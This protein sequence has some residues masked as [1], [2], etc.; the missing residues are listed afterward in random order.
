[1]D[2]NV[3]ESH[4]GKNSPLIVRLCAFYLRM[5]VRTL[6]YLMAA[7]LLLVGSMLTAVSSTEV[8]ASIRE[9][10]RPGEAVNFLVVGLLQFLVGIVFGRMASGR[11]LVERSDKATDSVL[12][13]EIS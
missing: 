3:G 4:A 13:D 1:M 8:I 7:V 11:W 9:G 10:S 6:A 2:E 12:F 5:I